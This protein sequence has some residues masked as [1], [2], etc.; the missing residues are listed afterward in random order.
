MATN[1]NAERGVASERI[2]SLL[3]HLALSQSEFASEL[4]ISQSYVS[5]I[6]A[7]TKSPSK[8]LIRAI[9]KKY[10]VLDYWWE[11][12][13]GKIT[14]LDPSEIY[15]VPDQAKMQREFVE[16]YVTPE[17]MTVFDAFQEKLENIDPKIRYAAVI[18]LNKYINTSL[19]KDALGLLGEQEEN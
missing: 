12:G 15:R 16:K 6:I 13:E 10:E 4:E 8:K 9:K 11:T 18:C 3:D 7:G 2:K 5:G 17:L 19:I 14:E 1:P